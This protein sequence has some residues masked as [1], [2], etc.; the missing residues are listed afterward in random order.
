MLQRPRRESSH[1]DFDTQSRSNLLQ[2][3]PRVAGPSNGGWANGCPCA[4]H[5]AII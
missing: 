2:M 4:C 3:E 1:S 5:M